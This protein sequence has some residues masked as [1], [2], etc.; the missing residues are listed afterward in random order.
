MSILKE[1]KKSAWTV[2]PAICRWLLPKKPGVPRN[3]FSPVGRKYHR[4]ASSSWNTEPA[5][6]HHQDITICRHR[7]CWRKGILDTGL[8][9]KRCCKTHMQWCLWT[10]MCSPCLLYS[11]FPP[12]IAH[13]PRRI[14][15]V[16]QLSHFVSKVWVVPNGSASDSSMLQQPKAP[17]AALGSFGCS[18]PAARRCVPESCYLTESSRWQGKTTQARILQY[19]SI[20]NGTEEARKSLL[21][22]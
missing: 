7:G 19:P 12:W 5:Q 20:T 16:S 18:L 2:I 8:F 15:V 4:W 17:T 10:R 22:C 11:L 13:T 9:P 3:Y 6:G 1:K 21:E 14:I